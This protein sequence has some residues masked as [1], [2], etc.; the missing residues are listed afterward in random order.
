MGTM[1]APPPIAPLARTA[2]GE[3]D[4]GPDCVYRS[5]RTM[6]FT[7]RA[8]EFLQDGQLVLKEFREGRN[9]V[10]VQVEGYC[11]R[12]LHH[13]TEITHPTAI[14]V[15]VTRSAEEATGA[16]GEPLPLVF[17]C[18]CEEDHAGRDGGV[19]GCGL[20]YRVDLG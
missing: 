9:V 3:A 13:H 19:K 11:P 8:F 10:S 2:E 14:G 18:R 15:G 5:V 7:Q 1:K 4:E 6:K 20:V 12:C 17:R 16:R